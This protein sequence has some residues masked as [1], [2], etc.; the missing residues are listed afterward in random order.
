LGI[1][2]PS[3]SGFS[4][5]MSS[6]P[7]VSIDS[8]SP[9]KFGHAM[10]DNVKEQHAENM[11]CYGLTPQDVQAIHIDLQALEAWYREH[12]PAVLDRYIRAT[13]HQINSRNN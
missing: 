10:L 6:S 11:T 12:Q 7:T 13:Q 1:F 5:G 3:H 8:I 4:C 2:G 9:K